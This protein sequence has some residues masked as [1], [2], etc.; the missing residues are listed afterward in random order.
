MLKALLASDEPSV[1]LK[2][3]TAVLGEHA[4]PDLLEQIRSSDRVASLLSGRRSDGS[5]PLHPYAK[6]C[7]A[8]WLLAILAELGYPPGDWSLVPLREQSAAE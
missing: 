1:R 7:G 6:W 2:V 5:V 3:R 4:S 8:H